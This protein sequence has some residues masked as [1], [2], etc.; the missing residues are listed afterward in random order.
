L[1]LDFTSFILA[2]ERREVEE[3]QRRKMLREKRGAR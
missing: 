2:Y 1:S 3:K